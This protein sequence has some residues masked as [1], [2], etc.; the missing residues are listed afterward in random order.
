MWLIMGFR[1]SPYEGPPESFFVGVYQEHNIAIETCKGLNAEKQ[2]DTHYVVREIEP[3]KVYDYEWNVLDEDVYN[4][5][6]TKY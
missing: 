4:Q 6:N 3:N 5:I 2:K 1:E